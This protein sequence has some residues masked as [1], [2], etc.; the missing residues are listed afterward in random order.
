MR[1]IRIATQLGFSIE[2]KTF[3]AI[4]NNANLLNKIS[5]ERIRDELLKLFSYPFAADGYL[6]MR[7]SGLAEKILPEVEASF[8]VQQKS[9]KR[10]HT[11]DVGTHSLESLKNSKS[12]DPIVNLAILLHDVGK[13]TVARVK[14]TELLLLQSRNGWRFFS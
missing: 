12:K 4:K 10:H 11:L 8:G 2:E 6:L 1:A 13:P 14:K 9:P 3:Q 5:A 7:N